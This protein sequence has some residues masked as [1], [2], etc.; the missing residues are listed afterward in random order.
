MHIS[1]FRL[2]FC[3]Q[4]QLVPHFSCF[5]SHRTSCHSQES[6]A[7]HFKC[8]FPEPLSWAS[9]YEERCLRH[10]TCKSPREQHIHDLSYLDDLKRRREVPHLLKSNDALQ[11][12]G[13]NSM[14]HLCVQS[15]ISLFVLQNIIFWRSKWPYFSNANQFRISLLALSGC[16]LD[17][18][19]TVAD[20][21]H[22][23]VATW[24]S[25]LLTDRSEHWWRS[26]CQSKNVHI[27]SKN[28]SPSEL[29][30]EMNGYVATV[31]ML[32]F[33]SSTKWNDW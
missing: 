23:T 12:Q 33:S 22:E 19:G 10:R 8:P 21:L 30:Q 14:Q 26:F 29:I 28:W 32:I 7:A 11:N 20:E 1:R 3:R 13:M 16:T 2:H 6:D 9:D 27:L 31:P 5:L 18:N 25:T 24:C 17:L 4:E 15:I